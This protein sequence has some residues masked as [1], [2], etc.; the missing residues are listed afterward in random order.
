MLTLSRAIIQPPTVYIVVYFSGAT[1]VMCTYVMC[2]HARACVRPYVRMH[3]SYVCV[4]N[5][6][7]FSRA[8][9]LIV[10]CYLSSSGRNGEV[11]VMVRWP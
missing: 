3:V 6:S 4:N 2:V 11:V 9:P 7:S 1:Y 8:C 10:S 5:I